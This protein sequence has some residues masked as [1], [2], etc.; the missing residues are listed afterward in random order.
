MRQRQHPAAK[1]I[2]GSDDAIN[3]NIYTSYRNIILRATIM[4]II[5]SD[6]LDSQVI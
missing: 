5:I 1:L 2:H 3:Q 4:M 6:Q